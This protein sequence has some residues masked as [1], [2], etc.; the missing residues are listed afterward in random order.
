M[1]LVDLAELAVLNK[2]ANIEIGN[3]IGNSSMLM[4]RN[5]LDGKIETYMITGNL[6]VHSAKF[7]NLNSNNTYHIK[8]DYPNVIM[9]MICKINH[10][11]PQNLVEAQL[12]ISKM[13]DDVIKLKHFPCYC[14]W[15]FV[16]VIHRWPVD[17]PHKG[18]WRRVWMFSLICVS[19]NG[20]ATMET[21]MIWYVIA[22]IVTSL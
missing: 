2:Q 22:L 21:P 14:S 10:I 1:K 20:W 5:F 13:Y 17:S 6:S 19:I 11:N 4:W 16:R 12:R 8:P 3:C 15:S 18:Q 7:T 9:M